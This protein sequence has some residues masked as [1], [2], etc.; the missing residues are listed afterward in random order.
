MIEKTYGRPAIA[1]IIGYVSMPD[2]PSE[3]IMQVR[4]EGTIVEIPI[5]AERSE[6]ILKNYPSGSKITVSFYNCEWHV[7]CKTNSSG[8]SSPRIGISISELLKDRKGPKDEQHPEA[9]APDISVARDQ[10]NMPEEDI[11]GAQDYIH[12]I[13]FEFKAEAEQLLKSF[14]LSHMLSDSTE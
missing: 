8:N 1:D 11:Q 3:T 12:E 2:R 5:D 13:E 9:P 4:I 10:D 7:E 14:K 6:S